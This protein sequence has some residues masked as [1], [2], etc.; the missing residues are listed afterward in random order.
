MSCFATQRIEAF[1]E[2]PED[3]IQLICFILNAVAFGDSKEKFL[4]R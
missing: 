3:V 2:T 4:C 1:V